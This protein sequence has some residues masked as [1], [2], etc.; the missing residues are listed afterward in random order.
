[1]RRVPLSRGGRA[2]ARRDVPL[3][4]VPAG[5]RLRL[6]SLCDLCARRRDDE[7][8]PLDVAQFRGRPPA[9]GRAA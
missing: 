2:E 8:Q 9:A 6:W 3:H 5:A 4:D 7:R 1:M